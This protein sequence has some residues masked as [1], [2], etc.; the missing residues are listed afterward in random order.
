MS[1]WFNVIND[2][3]HDWELPEDIPMSIACGS[4]R[5][6]VLEAKSYLLLFL[7]FGAVCAWIVDKIRCRKNNIGSGILKTGRRE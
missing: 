3:S 2:M 5:R 6:F 4:E 1:A 7:S